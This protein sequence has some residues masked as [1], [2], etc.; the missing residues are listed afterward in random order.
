LPV[1]FTLSVFMLLTLGSCG[2][3]K[4]KKVAA[5]ADT[6]D[7]SGVFT[8]WNG[9]FGAYR[10]A[11]F[12]LLDVESNAV[13]SAVLDDSGGFL[14]KTVDSGRSY[15]GLLLG[16]DFRLL[17]RLELGVS[18]SE[19]RL[20]VFSLG[21]TLGDL[22][23]LVV[24]EGVIHT[25]QRDSLEAETKLGKIEKDPVVFEKNLPKNAELAL[26]PDIDGDGIPNLIDGDVDG[27][28]IANI[29]DQNT[30]ADEY[31]ENI[32]WQLSYESN[33][34]D[35]GYL[36]C[37]Y[38]V[39]PAQVQHRCIL[40]SPRDSIATA[41]LR[42]LATEVDFKRASSGSGDQVWIAEFSRDIA[43]ESLVGRLALVDA[44]LP[45]GSKR[46]FISHLG[47]S[48]PFAFKSAS[49]ELRKNEISAQVE[50]T[51]WNE[52]EGTQLQVV[53]SDVKNSRVMVFTE[54]VTLP[55]TTFKGVESMFLGATADSRYQVQLRLLCP[56]QL[57]GL[58]G[59]GVESQKFEEQA[60]VL[61]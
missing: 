39:G 51:G 5:T 30:F 34:R 12:L 2:G 6:V 41:K 25:S 58:L 46:S 7:V 20:P 15:Y 22:G 43:A 3:E 24:R 31:N 50:L 10:G 37:S 11:S 42:T 61:E 57:P 59:S 35:F 27:D 49:V 36:S 18:G 13:S 28:G 17:G 55:K 38:L 21:T 52:P 14:I 16:S 32:S 9:A 56:G 29:L 8:E 48:L 60:L 26:D 1:A 33:V 45:D 23:V 40:Q 47:D 53:I 19:T 54:S 44:T 4:D